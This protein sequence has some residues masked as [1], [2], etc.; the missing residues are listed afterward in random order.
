LHWIAGV[1]AFV[2]GEDLGKRYWNA[3]LASRMPEMMAA[4][5]WMNP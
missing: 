1:L 3:R 2:S 5:S 4:A